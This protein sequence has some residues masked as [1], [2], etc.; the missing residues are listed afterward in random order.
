MSSKKKKTKKTIV[1]R[2]G[3]ALT[4]KYIETQKF[5]S[6]TRFFLDIRSKDTYGNATQSALRVYN[7]TDSNSASVI[8]HDNLKKLKVM[9]VN[10]LDQQGFGFGDLLKIGL[11]KMMEG[12]YSDWE[13][14]MERLGY[15]EKEP[16]P[17][18]PGPT[19][20]V[21]NIINDWK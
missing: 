9:S 18:Q 3:L 10:L 20:N 1:V 14:F 19:V 8:G 5:K 2:K 13:K 11:K 4:T 21:Q 6:W 15:F 7:T 12:D 16:T 17:D